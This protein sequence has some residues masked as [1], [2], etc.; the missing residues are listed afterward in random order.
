MS[1]V[2]KIISII[3]IQSYIKAI[4]FVEETNLDKI[5]RIIS[6]RCCWKSMEGRRLGVGL[7]YK[8]EKI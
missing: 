3:F 8:G 7:E 4:T 1:N 6:Q 5:S 2:E